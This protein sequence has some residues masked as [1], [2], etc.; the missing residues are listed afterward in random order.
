MRKE[1]RVLAVVVDEA[2]SSTVVAVVAGPKSPIQFFKQLRERERIM[3]CPRT[4]AG[5]L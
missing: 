3:K 1:P 4:L 5:V 2:L